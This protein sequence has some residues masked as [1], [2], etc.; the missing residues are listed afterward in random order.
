MFLYKKK[1]KKNYFYATR[2]ILSY[3]V[4]ICIAETLIVKILLGNV[5]R[6]NFDISLRAGKF[7]ITALSEVSKRYIMPPDIN[8]YTLFSTNVEDKFDTLVF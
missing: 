2:L 7:L 3:D 1:K 5:L 6:K 8:Y 4:C